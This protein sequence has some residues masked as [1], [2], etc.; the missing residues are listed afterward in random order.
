MKRLA[1]GASLIAFFFTLIVAGRADAQKYPRGCPTTSTTGHGLIAI[2]SPHLRPFH[3]S[4]RP[5]RRP[6]S[7]STMRPV[8]PGVPS[9][10]FKLPPDRPSSPFDAGPYTYAPRYAPR[11]DSRSRPLRPGYGYGSGYSTNGLPYSVEELSAAPVNEG[12]L[13]IV[14]DEP[15]GRL[16][17]D[18]EPGTAQVYVDG[19]PIGAVAGFRGVGM[20]LT[21]GLRHVELRSPGYDSVVF[22]IAVESN[23]PAV[24]RGDLTPA[25]TAAGRPV[26]PGDSSGFR[27]VLR[28]SGLLPRQPAAAGCVGAARLRHRESKDDQVVQASRPAWVSSAGLQACRV[29]SA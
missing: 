22:D 16:F 23:R 13:A 1:A 12:P 25:R 28:D 2:G 15:Q 14:A 24:Y 9:R 18:T 3:R 27:H 6:A 7:R 21:E 5:H 26:G 11:Y 19:T 4:R 8:T 17:I 20:L 29:L 10:E